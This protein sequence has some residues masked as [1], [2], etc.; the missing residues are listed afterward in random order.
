[1]GTETRPLV[2]LDA[3]CARVGY[4]GELRPTR[5]VL[6]G[7]HLAHATHVPFENL[8]IWLGRPIRLDLESLQAKIVHGR[9]GGYCFEHNTLFAAVLEQVG[10]PVTPMSARSRVGATRVVPRTHMT[11]E[12]N[13][14]GEPW[15]ADVGFGGEGPLLP[16]PFEPGRV[17]PQFAWEFRAVPEGELWVLQYRQAGPWQDLY[18]L[19]RERDYPGDFEMANYYVSTHPMSPF[20][21]RL[22]A[23]ATSP[24]GRS[25]L[26]DQELTVTRGET[27]TTRTL[28]GDEDL[29]RV[30]A[31]VF[32]LEFPPE[33]RFRCPLSSE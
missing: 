33:T 6:E 20:V 12:V 19:R 26:R 27:V 18:S 1:M 28:S 22:T 4:R 13:V 29:R 25:V 3:Y 7:L 21:R 14:E 30:L 23:Q 15:L 11:L 5:K 32:G 24:E 31:E 10:F 2:D 8:D 9:R 16:V 17:V